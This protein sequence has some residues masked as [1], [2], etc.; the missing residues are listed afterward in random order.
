VKLPDPPSAD[1]RLCSDEDLAPP[2]V[3]SASPS[4]R[5]FVMSWSISGCP[6]SVPFFR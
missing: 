4:P 3:R 5:R 6:E 1:A 2:L